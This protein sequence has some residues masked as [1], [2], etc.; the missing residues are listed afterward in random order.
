MSF[1]MHR[2]N[3]ISKEITFPS[4]QLFDIVR[5]ISRFS[6]TRVITF[7]FVNHEY[8]IRQNVAIITTEVSTI[9]KSGKNHSWA[10]YYSN[11]YHYIC[12]TSLN[13]KHLLR[14]GTTKINFI[15]DH[16]IADLIF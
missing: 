16:F 2:K 15:Q 12:I 10:Q 9:N 8:P 3:I 14:K 6:E 5:Y 7:S 13:I 11:L 1:I 4:D